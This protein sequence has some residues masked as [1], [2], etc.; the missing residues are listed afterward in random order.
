LL[1]PACLLT[2]ACADPNKSHILH[3]T[4][5]SD[6][7][8]VA[9]LEDAGTNTQILR[10]RDLD[11]DTQWRTVA[12]PLYTGTIQF[13]LQGHELLLTHNNPAA[14]PMEYLS[15]L[16]LDHPERGVEL[17]YEAGNLAF[18]VEVVPGQVMVRTRLPTDP[19]THRLSGYYWVLVGPGQQVQRVGPE[20]ILPY[21]APNIVGTGFFWVDRQIGESKAPHPKLLAYALPGGIVPEKPSEKFDKNTS[22]ISCDRRA[23]RCLRKYIANRGQAAKFIYAVEVF[24]GTERCPV[25]GVSGFGDRLSITPDGNAAVM[26]LAPSY[27][28]SRHVV[29]M[30]FK[31]QQCAPIS[32]RHIY[33]DKES[34]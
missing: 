15:K 2:T 12:V 34:S 23:N 16:D 9:V 21:S 28:D 8:M 30:H 32:V 19:G 24:L 3:T 20:K 27:D 29:V 7:R 5:S 26:S 1:A 33:F 17:I 11:T 14:S 22:D 31:P 18:P 4:I 13:R 10:V 6:G 25:P